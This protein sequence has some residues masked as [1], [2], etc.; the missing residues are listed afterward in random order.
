ML[1]IVENWD[2][3]NLFKFLLDVEAVWT[4]NVFQIYSTEGWGETFDHI[5]E[6]IFVW[7][8]NAN[9][10]AVDTGELLEEH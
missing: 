2:W 9:I 3:H 10:D 4:F 5:D 8:V 7:G 6:L 1:V